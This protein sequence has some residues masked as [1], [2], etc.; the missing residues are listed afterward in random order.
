MANPMP[1]PIQMPAASQANS[2]Q[3]SRHIATGERVARRAANT[4]TANH[5]AM[6]ATT[7]KNFR[8]DSVASGTPAASRAGAPSTAAP[9]PAMPRTVLV[10]PCNNI[11]DTTPSAAAGPMATNGP[12]WRMRD[13]NSRGPC[14][15]AM[16][17]RVPVL[18]MTRSYR[19]GTAFWWQTITTV[20]LAIV[21]ANIVV[22]VWSRRPA[23][24]VLCGVLIIVLHRSR[25]FALLCVGAGLFGVA[26]SGYAWREVL[27]EHLGEYHARACLK[28]DP[29][30]VG[31]ATLAVFEIEGERFETWAR[32]SARRRLANRLAGECAQVSGKRRALNGVTAHRAAIRHVV[33]GF[34]LRT[35]G[36]WDPGT[37]LDRASNRVRRLF[38]QGAAALPS[39]DDA[40]FAGLVIGDDRNEPSAMIDA[41]RGSGLSHLTAVSGQNVAFILAAAAPLLRRLRAW[42][43]WAATLALIAWFAALTRFEPSVL[44]AGVMA[45]I[46]ATGYL[47]GRERPAIRVLVLAVGLLILVDPLLVWSVGFWLSVGATAGVA[48]IGTALTPYIPGPRWFAEPAAVTLGAQ[49]GVAPVSL[50][51][52]GT[53]PL[54]SIPANLLAVPVAGF[55]MLYGLPAGLVAGAT[56][57][58][59]GGTVSSIVQMPSALGTRWVATVAGLGY[60]LEPPATWVMCGWVA[61]VIAVACRIV[62]V[63]FGR[64]CQG[65]R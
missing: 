28:A 52:F 60:K 19:N 15:T 17:G 27:P 54:V 14:G 29:A 53:L 10:L 26:V 63:R 42:V 20:Q 2:R 40:L 31:G 23:L 56:Q 4:P 64:M 24:A 47:M 13:R 6:L 62:S 61:V 9:K 18:V 12:R 32:G 45:A 33:G 25:T 57:H 34:Q 48:V 5:S 65:G 44:R 46:A 51:I 3:K 59:V 49:C 55:V 7:P 8:L 50:L 22:G 30:P 16:F 35:I 43:R 21:V 36:D 1:T 58:F 38:A 39:P 11:A 41:F 37:A